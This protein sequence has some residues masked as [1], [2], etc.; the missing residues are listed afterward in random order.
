MALNWRTKGQER[1]F[2]GH[3]ARYVAE[4]LRIITRAAIGLSAFACSLFLLYFICRFIGHLIQYLED[5][6][7]NDLW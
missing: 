2:P 4:R 7:F 1:I 5:T 3:L 6:M